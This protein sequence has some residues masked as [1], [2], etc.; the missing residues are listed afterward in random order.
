MADD[1]IQESDQTP[2]ARGV[3]RAAKKV[4]PMGH[5]VA[6]YAEVQATTTSNPADFMS[7]SGSSS[8]RESSE[9]CVM[10]YHR[11]KPSRSAGSS[12]PNLDKLETRVRRSDDEGDI[13]AQFVAKTWPQQTKTWR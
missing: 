1:T 2:P 12:D 5:Q 11:E 10:R 13:L 4:L 3:G 9:I 7:R 8:R 6:N